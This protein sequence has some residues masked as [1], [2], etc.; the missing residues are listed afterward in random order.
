WLREFLGL[1][2]VQPA[3]PGTGSHATPP[4][5]DVSQFACADDKADQRSRS[6]MLKVGD[7]LGKRL[8]IGDTFEKCSH[9]ILWQGYDEAACLGHL[10]QLT[11]SQTA[12]CRHPCPCSARL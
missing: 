7:R 2:D 1:I 9:P 4:Q 11:R 10:S 3:E 12:A 8:L 6:A 5:A